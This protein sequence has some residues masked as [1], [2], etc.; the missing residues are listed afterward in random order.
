MTSTPTQTQ[1]KQTILNILSKLAPEADLENLKPD[2]D[3]R[4]KLGIDSYDFLNLM[5]GL[6]EIFGVEI[7]EA[8]YGK[9]VTLTD[10]I[11]YISSSSG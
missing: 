1:I 9:L 8:D 11:R 3:I 10:M 5:I 4:A 7:P 6:N 2:E